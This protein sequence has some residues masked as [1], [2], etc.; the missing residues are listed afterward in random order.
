M[1]PVLFP[2]KRNTVGK[3]NI[4]RKTMNE[5]EKQLLIEFF[6]KGVLSYKQSIEAIELLLGGEVDE[7]KV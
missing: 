7:R 2:V 4:R 3:Q 5:E 1:R 6:Q